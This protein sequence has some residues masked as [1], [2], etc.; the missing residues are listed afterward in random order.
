MLRNSK[1]TPARRYT[2]GRWVALALIGLGAIG[3]I[4]IR[5]Q[6][7]AALAQ[8]PSGGTA[9][10][11]SAVEYDLKYVSDEG[12]VLLLARPAALLADPTLA[13]FA[14]DINQLPNLE[15][16]RN[17]IGLEPKDIE[18]IVV[19]TNVVFAGQ[20]PV[21]S[22]VSLSLKTSKP[23]GKVESLTGGT[24]IQIGTA[25]VYELPNDICIWQPNE[26]SLVINNKRNIQR[27]IE[28]R[29]V[30]RKL[31]N[32]A[33]WKQLQDQP[34]VL[35]LDGE[36]PRSMLSRFRQD[37]N[38]SVQFLPVFAPIIDEAD[39]MGVA[40]SVG[41][42]FKV[43]ALAQCSDDKGVQVVQETASAAIVLLKNGLKEV[44]RQFTSQPASPLQPI[45]AK[46]VIAELT[47]I[48]GL[49][50]ESASIK[51]TENIASLTFGVDSSRVPTKL[52]ITGV[53]SARKA[54]QRTQSTNNLKQIGLAFHNHHDAYKQF[55]DSSHKLG[56]SKY[57]CSWRVAILPFIEQQALY[58]L[59]NFDEPW[60]SETN[61]KVLQMMPAIYRHP[62][63][64][65]SSP[66][67]SYVLVTGP[68]MM[69]GSSKKPQLQTVTDGTSNTIMVV[70]AKTSIPWTKPEDFEYATNGK[71]PPFGGYSEEGYNVVFGDGSVRFLSKNIDEK[72]LRMLLT[73][74]GGEVIQNF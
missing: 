17:K 23:I 71:L 37:P 21:P 63:N 8:A 50:L 45:E 48:A 67:T 72:M 13:N 58:Q 14:D 36:I 18:Q 19:G 41:S 56:Q 46:Q 64:N 15:D 70:E 29:K 20:E 39:M 33:I 1:A 74:R 38:F 32:T 25:T 65:E 7:N 55:P 26:N 51:T 49:M 12:G 47:N 42:Q 10:T 24:A 59:Y 27:F 69:F 16:L 68:D 73:P 43:T 11:Q 52:L 54:A 62:S 44:N 66:N 57:P 61:L 60:D 31:T 5:P 3:L 35:L 2:A 4:G 53:S 9:T 30:E 6:G 40:V 28:G 34:A 22:R